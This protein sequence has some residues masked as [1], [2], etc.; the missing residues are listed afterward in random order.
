[1]KRSRH[2]K[3]MDCHQCGEPVHNVSDEVVK[4]TCWRCVSLSMRGVPPVIK[5]DEPEDSEQ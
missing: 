4:V 3:S 1:M 2:T 5:E